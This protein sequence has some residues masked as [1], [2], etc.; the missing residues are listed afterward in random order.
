MIRDRWGEPIMPS[1]PNPA[2]PKSKSWLLRIFHWIWRKITG[3]VG[4]EK[5]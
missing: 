2:R 3:R 5:S 1:P 4:R